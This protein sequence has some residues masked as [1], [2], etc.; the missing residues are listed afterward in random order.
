MIKK[1]LSLCWLLTVT[2]S[3][4]SQVSF[5]WQRPLII[6]NSNDGINFS[7]FQTFQDSSGVPS[8]IR[9]TT[10]RLVAAFQWFPMPFQGAHWD[11]VALKYSYDNGVTWT[12]AQTLYIN[13]YPAGFQRIF[14]PSLCLNADGSIRIYF[15][16][17]PTG[18]VVSTYSAWSADGINFTFE[19]GIRFT[20]TTQNTIDPTVIF[21]NGQY[22]YF[23][24]KGAPQDGSLH[25]TSPDGLNF[26]QQADIPSDVQHNWTGNVMIDS[27]AIKFYGT[28]SGG[29]NLWFKPSPDAF[30]WNP[31]Y[32]NTNVQGGDP[33][34]IKTGLAQYLMIYTGPPYTTSLPEISQQNNLTIFP[35][36]SSDI[37]IVSGFTG[38]ANVEIYD[39]TSRKIYTQF[40]ENG[41][42]EI[43]CSSF[44]N[45]IYTVR[46]GNGFLKFVKR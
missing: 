19:P 33:A 35:D 30:T 12:S 28:P 34:C 11:S 43:N 44:S 42:A 41:K 25:A 32:T 18:G 4:Y 17:S 27:L 3:A 26:T 16:S 5:P 36:P 38:N 40:A 2:C 1:I 45:G 23:A 37:I 6:C 22:H 39:A 29:G 20:R 7:N 8:L 9:D 31:V 24:P 14:D 21:Y 13:N 46:V 10:G 15:S